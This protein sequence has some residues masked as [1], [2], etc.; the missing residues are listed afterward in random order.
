MSAAVMALHG[1][2]ARHADHP[3]PRPRRRRRLRWPGAPDKRQ[4]A[5]PAPPR[6][7]RRRPPPRRGAPRRR[8]K[9]RSPTALEIDELKLE[10]GY[11]LLPLVNEHGR[12]DRLTEQIKALRRQLAAELGFVMPPVRILDNMQLEPNAYVDPHQGGRGRPAARSAPAS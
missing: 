1:A 2:P 11:G 12:P 3:V 4:K 10:L 5:A 8:A 7:R 6:T 9:S